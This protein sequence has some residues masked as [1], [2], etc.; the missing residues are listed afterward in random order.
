MLRME[1]ISFWYVRFVTYAVSCKSRASAFHTFLQ[2]TTKCAVQY[3]TAGNTASVCRMH[4][5]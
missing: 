1:S 4:F 3:M 5:M 2:T